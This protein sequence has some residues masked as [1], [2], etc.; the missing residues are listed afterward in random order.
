MFV[1]RH[2]YIEINVDSRKYTGRHC[3]TNTHLNYWLS[4]TGHVIILIVARM[5]N[6]CCINEHRNIAPRLR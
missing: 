5:Q 3:K 1:C 4:L 6:T 2:V